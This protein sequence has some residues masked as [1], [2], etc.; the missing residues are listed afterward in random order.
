MATSFKPGLGADGL[1]HGLRGAGS[2]IR[3]IKCT[4]EKPTC[5]NCVKRKKKC[6][7]PKTIRRRGPDKNPGSRPTAARHNARSKQPK[8]QPEGQAAEGAAKSKALAGDVTTPVSWQ[9]E[10]AQRASGSH[11]GLGPE[12]T[13][14]SGGGTAGANFLLYQSVLPTDPAGL[15]A[16][17]APRISPEVE[18]SLFT[19]RALSLDQS[20]ELP[21]QA[22]EGDILQPAIDPSTLN[23]FQPNPQSRQSSHSHPN[24][25]QDAL[26]LQ[27]DALGS[28]QPLPA[29]SGCLDQHHISPHQRLPLNQGNQEIP[30]FQQ[31]PPLTQPLSSDPT[32]LDC[33]MSAGAQTQADIDAIFVS[34]LLQGAISSGA[35]GFGSLLPVAGPGA[36]ADFVQMGQVMTEGTNGANTVLGQLMSLGSS[37]STVGILSVSPLSISPSMRVLGQI[38]SSSPGRA[39]VTGVAGMAM[40]PG[41]SPLKDGGHGEDEPVRE[42]KWSTLVAPIELSKP[43]GDIQ[44]AK[45]GWWTWILLKYSDDRQVANRMVINACPRCKLS[46]LSCDGGGADMRHYS[47]SDRHIWL[48]F[49]QPDVFFHSLF[50]GATSDSSIFR[51][52]AAPHMLL[53]ILAHVTLL[54]DGHTREGQRRAFLF[55][56]EALSL[57]SYCMHAGSQ[58][59]SLSAAGLILTVLEIQPH[60][61]HLLD[62]VHSFLA[63]L[64]GIG[65]SVYARHL[66]ADE[67]TVSTSLVGY[68]RLRSVLPAPLRP[69][70]ILDRE[71]AV[72]DGKV[73]AHLK[74]WAQEPLWNPNWT[75]AEMWKEEMRRMCWCASGLAA[76]FTL[77]QSVRGQ[78]WDDLEI[79][80]PERFRLLFP[81]EAVHIEL[82]NYEGGKTTPWAMYHR[83]TSLW[84]F[85]THTVP[86]TAMQRVQVLN[87]LRAL[88]DDMSHMVQEG[89]VRIYT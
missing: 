29:T 36:E 28:F 80:H 83:V 86:L 76:H 44:A 34:R 87:E 24:A 4:T 31:M 51:L 56:A 65:L 60:V 54:R 22:Q 13:G 12:S 9:E 15:A 27:G 59:P 5:A 77:R 50:F 49:L 43:P 25:T 52:R 20:A 39:G 37:S 48:N 63:L 84:H 75:Q 81:G 78:K 18:P 47:F 19:A 57:I 7:Y 62:R 53:A 14:S 46:R 33:R 79:C 3:K 66:D 2:R 17:L 30:P 41:V 38:M 85:V 10:E 67:R 61:E 70:S 8:R 23:L 16:L 74:A 26:P 55:A 21:R 64:N 82:G 71:D 45:D 40:V 1:E 58:D 73:D 69:K 89:G 32:S 68:L 42:E 88:E 6:T 72:A 11:A 35:D